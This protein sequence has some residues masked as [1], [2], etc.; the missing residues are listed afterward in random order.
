MRIGG[1]DFSGSPHPPCPPSPSRRP[2]PEEEGGTMGGAR[3][4]PPS[5][6][7]NPR[8]SLGVRSTIWR[9]IKKTV[10]CDL[11]LG[12]ASR[13]DYPVLTRAFTQ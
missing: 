9:N 13:L 6:R 11:P 5:S 2:R 7:A 3:G 4:A 8:Y 1:L 10:E 12:T